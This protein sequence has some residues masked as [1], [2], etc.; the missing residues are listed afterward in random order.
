M[1]AEVPNVDHTRSILCSMLS[2]EYSLQ[3]GDY[4]NWW[5]T[6]DEAYINESTPLTNRIV[7]TLEY[8]DYQQGV[9][10]MSIASPLGDQ[11]SVVIEFQRLP[12]ARWT[13]AD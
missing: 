12:L 3:D 13:S 8:T 5:F 10:A 7:I 2:P 1:E 4:R 9:K 6:E 11:K